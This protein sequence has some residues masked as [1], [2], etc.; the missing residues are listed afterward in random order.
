MENNILHVK[1]DANKPD[2]FKSFGKKVNQA[3]SSKLIS[4]GVICSSS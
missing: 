4:H 3:C 1:T 2:F